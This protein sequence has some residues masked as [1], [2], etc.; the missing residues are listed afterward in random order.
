MLLYNWLSGLIL[1]I[2]VSYRVQDHPSRPAAVHSGLGPPSSTDK[3]P[4]KMCPQDYLI[5]FS[6]IICITYYSSKKRIFFITL[7]FQSLRVSLL[8]VWLK[9]CIS[10]LK[11]KL[12]LLQIDEN[13]NSVAILLD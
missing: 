4:P 8:H 10:E 7:I 9:N 12:S 11:K 13:I 3:Q 2:L 5:F 1:F 6:I